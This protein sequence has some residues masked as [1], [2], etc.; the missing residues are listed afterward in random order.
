[1][2]SMMITLVFACKKE[3]VNETENTTN[4][5]P[6]VV[7]KLKLDPSQERTDNLGNPSPL[8]A[9]HGAQVPDFNAFSI[10]Y[11]ELAQNAYTQLQD[12]EICYTGA[13]TDI[14]GSTAIDFDKSVKVNDGGVLAEIPISQLKADTYKWL[15]VSVSYQNADI[16][17]RANGIDATATLASFLGYN[18][19]ISEHTIK[20]Q[21]ESI[22]ANKLQGYWAIEIHPNQSIPNAIVSNGEAG[23]ITV[24]NPLAATS[25]IPPGSCVLTGD[26]D[27]ELVISG[28]E[29]NDVIVEVS[30]STNN[31]FEWYDVAQNGIYEPLDGDTLVDMGI[32]GMKPILIQ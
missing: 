18:T 19:Y 30:F 31:S 21:S 12:G 25:P 14:G 2:Y 4:T 7:F 32:R 9:N 26:F 10:H 8:P 23:Q 13:S 20:T 16:E 28:N 22:N 24:P 29:K 6:K 3:E 17:F 5:E 1:M 27:Q 11:I 15:R